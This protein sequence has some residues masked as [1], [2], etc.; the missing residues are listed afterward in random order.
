MSLSYAIVGAGALG[1]YYGGRLAQ[2]GKEVHFLYH[3][4]YDYVKEHGLSVK[5][6]KGDFHLDNMNVYNDSSL[7][8][9]C[10][11]IL[12]TLKTT[13]NDILPAIL[14]S[15]IKPSSVVVLVQN[16]LGYE[17]KL[18]TEMPGVRIAGALA[19]ICA[20]RVSQGHILHAD[21]GEITLGFHNFTDDELAANIKSD[22]ESSNVKCIF[23][24]DLNFLRWRKLVWNIPYNGLAVALH[25]T[26]DRLMKNPSS[27]QLVTDLMNEVVC[28]ARA[29][30][31]M[32]KPDFVQRM[33][34]NTD[35]M[36]P[37]APS[38]R[39]DYDNHRKME[40]EAIYSNPFNIALKA[41]YEMKKVHMLEQQLRFI[42]ACEIDG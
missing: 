22:F 4:E 17:Q 23:G 15:L 34:D 33:L 10:D 1:G 20:S 36:E 6:V 38:M 30:G 12:V 9:K 37:Y 13:Q 19:F 29:C 40:I 3:T 8:P 5:S 24:N 35:N 21:Y 2:N 41:G 7:M 26:T 14:P 28:G 31:A 39:L 32:I 18:G 27:R 11:V 16:G 42:Q 25:T